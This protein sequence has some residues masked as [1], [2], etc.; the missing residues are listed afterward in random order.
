[1]IRQDEIK[2][3]LRTRHR[4]LQVLQEQLAIH[5][6]AEAPPRII[7]EIEDTE[8]EI[9]NLQA[10]LEALENGPA[11]LSQRIELQRQRIAEGMDEIHQRATAAP[12]TEQQQIHVVGRPPLGTVE[13][14]K[15]RVREREKIGQLLAESTTRLIS[16]IGHGGMGKTALVSKI[17]RNLE[18][19]RWPR[20]DDDIYLDGIVYLSTRTAGIT[21]ERLFLDCAKLLGGEQEKQ[22]NTI[23][24]NPKL[25]TNDK[26]AQLLDA[27]KE[28]QYVILLDNLE[29][30]L[31]DKG[32]LVDEDL[33]LFFD[34]S[35]SQA[36][37]MRLVITSRV[38]VAFGREVMRYD[39]QIKLL[40]GLPI[41]EGIELLRELDP[42]GDYGLQDA[43]EEQLAQAVQLVHGVP[44]AL[45]VMAG[46]LA[47]DPF[48]SLNEVMAQF[49]EQ[50]DVVEALIEENYK[51]LNDNARRVIEALAVFRRPVPPLALD[52]LLEPFVPG[53]DVPDIIRRLARTNII[54]IDR[55]NKTVI[56][57]P[58][59]RDYAYSQLPDK[60]NSQSG[61]SHQ[62]LER[63]AA[64]W[65]VQLRT[66]EEAWKT[67]DDLQ[68][69]LAEFEHRIRAE[70]Y[71]HASQV[72][73]SIDYDY[74]FLWGYYTSLIS[75]RERLLG[76]L[77]GSAQMI[78]LN[79]LGL[80]Y[81][82]V[83][84]GKRAVRHYEES[85]VIAREIG[86][87][88][89]EGS[90]LGNLGYTYHVLGHV[91]Q[92]IRLY[93]ESLTIARETGDRQGE[94]I[95]LGNLGDVYRTLGQIE[96]AVNLHEQ[97]LGIA[98]D[99]NDR[100]W[101]GDSLGLLGRTYQDLG[102]IDQAI[103]FYLQALKIA[104]EIS[105]HWHESTWLGNLGKIYSDIGYKEQ[106]IKFLEEALVIS[107]KIGNHRDESYQ[108][109][110]LS[111]IQLAI[112][113]PIRAEEYCQEVISLNMPE[114]NYIAALIIGIAL[115]HQQSPV[116]TNKHFTDT[117]IRCQDVIQ[118]TTRL[119]EARYTLASALVGQ[120]VT[121]P[122]W[123][124]L[125][126]RVELLTPALTEYQR[127]L[128]ICG[129]PGV[130]QGALRD[131]ELIRTA[132][133]EGLEPVFELLESAL[134]KNDVK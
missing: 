60:E 52:Y 95:W 98:R 103:E 90:I 74:L 118:K 89:W 132:G 113:E 64:D 63:R 99:I 47:N 45:E 66:P 14:F 108:L 61:I 11:T 134:A 122:N 48:V 41:A 7:L 55:V 70:D 35:L 46:I 110:W 82:I 37:G 50:E 120:I 107:Q 67:I 104:R 34:Q 57:H 85:L 28:G 126:K 32:Q 121:K 6:R 58:I 86:D 39:N 31:D 88:E 4:Y 49:Y 116:D 69:Q 77:A 128:E 53:L 111:K 33:R 127:A 68:P 15:N 84:Q 93:Q 106:A 124:Q 100:R 81:G 62:S 22:I 40:E 72:L 65:Y 79:N 109:L 24:T 20:M 2:R 56:L 25:N 38:A 76:Q 1:M 97:A 5:G 18:Q 44:R 133:V 115:L 42:N 21:L 54:S 13:H 112:E 73:E 30:L 101:E 94:S 23:W 19:H 16:V 17:L 51:R 26:I 114:N 12:S 96:K 131:L 125:E 78:N 105:D 36:H 119:V 123:T 59:D 87:R 102:Y 129:A 27:L 10:E 83:G 130:V 8:T 9:E 29:D 117:T 80:I 91:E 92:A 43:P 71:D 3:L 75:L